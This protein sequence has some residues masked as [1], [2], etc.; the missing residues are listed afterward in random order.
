MGRSDL[1]LIVLGAGAAGLPAARAAPPRR[2]W[3]GGR[4]DG[5]LRAE[6]DAY[7]AAAFA[8]VE[9]AGA[10]GRD[11][12]AATV[13][14][15]HPRFGRLFGPWFAALNGLEAERASTLDFARAALEGGNWRVEAGYG[16]LLAH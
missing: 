16:A 11:V 13:I 3:S 9:T 1:D 12:A 7:G 10:A 14:P 2:L 4:F 15:P 8:A 5:A 6:L